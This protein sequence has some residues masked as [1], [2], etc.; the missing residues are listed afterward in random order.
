MPPVYRKIILAFAFVL[1][2]QALFFS[3]PVRAESITIACYKDYRPYSYVNAKG[4]PE[5]ALIDFWQMWGKKNHVDISFIPGALDQSL[6]RVHKGEADLMIGVFKSKER[7]AGLDFSKPMFDVHTNLYIRQDMDIETI[8]ELTSATPVGVIKGDFVISYFKTRHPN[9]KVKVFAGSEQVVKSVQTG[10]IK[11]YALDFPNAI[12][13][14]AEHDSL[15]RFRILKTLYTEKL[16]AAVAKGNAPLLAM[17]NK[18][19][20]SVS[21]EEIDELYSKWGIRP[22]PLIVKYRAWI[23]G[24]IVLL[25]GGCLGFGVYIFR[26]K[27]RLR[28]M[29]GKNQPFDREEWKELI[30]QGENDWVEF[31]SSLVWNMKTQKSDKRMEAVVIKTLSAFMNARGGT[32]FIGINDE[33]QVLGLE[34]DYSSF[35]KKPNRDGFM[36]KLSS[37]ISHHL[38]RQSHKFIVTD[39]QNLDGHDVCRITV[40]PGERPVFVKDQGKESFYI[41]AG[42]ASVPLTMSES[43]EYI[44]SRW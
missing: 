29:G 15:T 28:S 42:A 13:L 17:I 32:L 16:R 22:Q 9:L 24:A 12:F 23:V 44:S 19:I 39:I 2:G 20:A 1:L 3:G 25:W 5:G 4:E 11:A 8:E 27:S 14:L 10:K 31:K 38:G 26:L 30:F 6:E 7:L 41:R 18:G 37:L 43:H 21:K 34:P 35:Q 40:K 33:G 36:L